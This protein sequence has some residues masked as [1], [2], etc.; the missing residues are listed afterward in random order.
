MNNNYVLY[1][2]TTPSG[3][4]YF[5]IT[6]QKPERRWSNGYGYKKNDHFW[7]AI[8]KYGWSNIGHYIL[9]DNL[10]ENEACFFEQIMIA[11]YD[12]TNRNNGYNQTT[13]GE[14]YKH[15]EETKMRISESMKAKCKTED[16]KRKMSEAKLGFKH[17]RSKSVI[18]LTT[19]QCFGSAREAA[20]HY[21][22]YSNAHISACCNG[23]RNY[24]GKLPDGTKLVWRYLNYK[25]DNVYHIVGGYYIDN[26]RIARLIEESFGAD[27]SIDYDNLPDII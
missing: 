9:A 13:G 18:C 26:E 23:E 10:T 3:K 16:T 12:T 14:C 2:H 22:F 17:P 15:T 25:H 5:G 21:N 24:S 7:N 4:R 6:K 19:R 20:R 27:E 8:K 1:M 11:I